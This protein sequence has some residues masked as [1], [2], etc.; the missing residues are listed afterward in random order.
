MTL[1]ICL[2][3]VRLGAISR[4]VNR[5]RD[6]TGFY[7]LYTEG[8]LRAMRVSLSID[9]RPRL[10]PV[11]IS[12]FRLNFLAFVAASGAFGNAT[13]KQTRG[14][15]KDRYSFTE[16]PK[17]SRSVRKRFLRIHAIATLRTSTNDGVNYILPRDNN[18]DVQLVHP[19]QVATLIGTFGMKIFVVSRRRQRYES[20][21]EAERKKSRSLPDFVPRI[22]PLAI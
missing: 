7:P 13:R 21:I 2:A 9:S 14:I 10:F 1:R 19:F 6:G 22:D 17:Y 8:R 12:S 5:H 4:Q 16:K 15:L 20:E 3:S 18:A 11:L